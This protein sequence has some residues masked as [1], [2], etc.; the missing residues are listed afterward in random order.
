MMK[1]INWNQSICNDGWKIQELYGGAMAIKIPEGYDDVS[2][3]RV[4]PDHQEVFVEKDWINSLIIEL[5][6]DAH[7][8]K[9]MSK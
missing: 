3:I 9:N 7:M 4:V 2:N 1:P 6:D 8:D 5:L